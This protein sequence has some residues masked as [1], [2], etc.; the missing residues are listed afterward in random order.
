[1]T[2]DHTSLAVTNVDDA[3]AFYRSAFGYEAIFVERG[4]S[5]QAESIVGLPG[6]RCDLAQLRSP[7]STHTLELIAFRL[8]EGSEHRGPIMPGKAHVAFVV[9]DLNRAIEKACSLGAAQLGMITQFDEGRAVYMTE[10]S[11]TVFELFESRV[12]E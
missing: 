3:V 10:P 7:I 6:L 8:P 9:T 2:W 1:V 11:G 4:M 5:A 12:G